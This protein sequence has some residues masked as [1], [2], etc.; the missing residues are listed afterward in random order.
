[1]E[2]SKNKFFDSSQKSRISEKSLLIKF[3]GENRI[4]KIIDFLLE[5]KE[6]DV[7]K[8]E[9]INGQNIYKLS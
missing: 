2:T 9:I 1:M 3:L 5:N 6:L 4:C 8:K 7:K